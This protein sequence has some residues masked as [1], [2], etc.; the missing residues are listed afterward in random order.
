MLGSAK[1]CWLLS[2]VFKI[3]DYYRELNLSHVTTLKMSESLWQSEL[4]TTRLHWCR[5][6]GVAIRRRQLF[7]S[8]NKLCSTT[9]T[10]QGLCFCPSGQRPLVALYWTHSSLSISLLYLGTQNWILNI[11]KPRS[12]SRQP[13]SISKDGNYN[14]SGQPVSV[15]GQPPSK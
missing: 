15:L 6:C 14:L 3:K 2:F 9:S 12:T 13:L 8:L 10:I 11:A 1:S 5:C 7:S 4:S